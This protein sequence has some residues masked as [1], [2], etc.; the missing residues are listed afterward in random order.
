MVPA[1]V[2]E[3]ARIPVRRC[4]ERQ[5]GDFRYPLLLRLPEHVHQLVHRSQV[6]EPAFDIE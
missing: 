3:F 1:I 4:N 6:V 2:A 5:S